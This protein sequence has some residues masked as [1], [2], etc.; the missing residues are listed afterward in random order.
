[1]SLTWMGRRAVRY[2]IVL[3][4]LALCVY[5]IG[6]PQLPRIGFATAVAGVPVNRTVPTLTGDQRLGGVLTCGRGTWDDPEGA[7]VRDRVPV[8]PRQP[9]PHRRDRRDA[10]DRR[11]RHRPRRCAATSRATGDYGSTEADSPTFYPPAPDALTPPRLSGDL[12]LGRTLVLHPRHV[13]RRRR[14]R[15]PDDAPRGCA[16]APSIAG[17]TAATYTV[18]RRGRRPPD[19]VPRQR[20]RRSR[21]RPPPASTPTAP[22]V[23]AI[24]QISGDLRL[25]GTLSCSRGTWD[26][27]GLTPY[28]TTKQWLRDGAEILGAD[29]RR[30]HG[31]PR[32]HRPLPSAAAC[33]PRT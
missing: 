3:G 6:K 30:L 5:A 8:G 17:Q 12:R 14:P 29:R 7:A 1:M 26:D 24:P 11:R 13:E 32:R 16:T 10:H 27:E 25:G 18:A 9:G 15:L 2:L 23:R 21:A 22:I 4:L 20:P 33:A 28:A 31:P 19:A